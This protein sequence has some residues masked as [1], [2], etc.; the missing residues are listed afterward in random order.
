MAGPFADVSVVVPA[1][2]AAAT[3]GRTLDSIADQTLKPRQVVVVDDGSDDGTFEAATARADAMDGI[4]LTV[5][6]QDNRG[7][8]AARNHAVVAATQ[9]LLAFLDADDE[10]LPS[11]LERTMPHL[12]DG[13]YVLVAHDYL[14][15]R[16]GTEAA[17]DCVGNFRA[18]PDPLVSLYRRGYIATTTVVARRDAV[19]AAGGF[20]ETLPNAQDF[21]LWLSML[22]RPD[23]RF[24]VFGEALTRYNV[25]PG[26]VMH[27]VMRR[28]R[29]CLEVARRYSHDL[30]D[31]PGWPLASVAFRVVALHYEAV[32]AF[33]HQGRFLAAAR[34]AAATPVSLAA[35][36]LA[37]LFGPRPPR[38]DFLNPPSTYRQYLGRR[39]LRQRLR[40]KARD[41]A[42]FALSVGRSPRRRGGWIRFPYYHH[43][44]D[45]ER[46]G[47]ARQ[48]NA[49]RAW[50]EFIALDDAIA[51]LAAGDPVDGRYFCVTFDDG[52][53]SCRTNALPILADKG[54]PATV[55]LPTRYIDTRPDRDRDLLMG[56]YDDRRLVI[57]FLGWGDCR[58][59]MAAGVTFGS[60]TESHAN[61]AALDAAGVEGEL[62]RSKRTIEERTGTACAHFCAPFGLP[63]V[64]FDPDRDPGIAR[65]LGY[66]SFL[67]GVRG[68]MRTGDS[69]M[70]VR[71]DHLLA[72]W[73][74]HQLRYFFSHG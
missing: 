22:S 4:E 25:T 24:H 3:I 58:E 68:A 43:V 11:K 50:G 37:H 21:A 27:H 54:V 67:S 14:F 53:R 42:V 10:W 29:C 8:G 60:H 16:D 35:L 69:P 63:R 12:E 1:Y 23:T 72:S 59:M 65:R 7:P 61:L 32:Q 70:M 17:V 49:M 30:K 31:R 64:H 48:L 55:F 26:S 36:T 44:F 19:I 74:A 5:L 57:D 62:D 20:D 13:R 47:F 6:R 71:R 45:D 28:L 56:F 52:F 41:A 46:S 51:L 9:P 39:S 34:V 66:R 33:R 38:P 40:A 18:G 2:R 73:G 15:A